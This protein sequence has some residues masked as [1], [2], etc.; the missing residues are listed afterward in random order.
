M[1]GVQ[2]CALPISTR[3]VIQARDIFDLYIL[4]SQHKPLKTE[5][6]KT[7]DAK[8]TQAYENVFEVS[9]EQFRDTVVSYLSPEDQ[10]LYNSLSLWDEIKLKAA[11]LIDELRRQ[12]A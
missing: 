11:N 8:L 3:S 6:I 4:S 1:T 9:F 12:H 7:N 10:T 5:E 2:T